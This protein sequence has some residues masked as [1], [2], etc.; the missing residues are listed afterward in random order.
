MGVKLLR[1]M[2]DGAKCN[3][4]GTETELGARP[5]EIVGA[6]PQKYFGTNLHK[7]TLSAHLQTWQT[8]STKHLRRWHIVHCHHAIRMA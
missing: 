7:C 2:R 5:F 6:D 8:V 1:D 4:C 3:V